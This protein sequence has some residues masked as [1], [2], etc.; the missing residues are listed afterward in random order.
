MDEKSQVFF[1]IYDAREGRFIRC[2]NALYFI[3]FTINLIIKS[4]VWK[5]T[6]GG[7]NGHEKTKGFYTMGSLLKILFLEDELWQINGRVEI[8]LS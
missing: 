5:E 1:S 7:K 8:E 4:P 3:Y 6:K 2:V